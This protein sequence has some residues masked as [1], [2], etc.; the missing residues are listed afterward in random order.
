MM[1]RIPPGRNAG[2]NSDNTSNPFVKPRGLKLRFIT[3][4]VLVSVSLA[5]LLFVLHT[6]DYRQDQQRL[7]DFAAQMP[8]L[9]AQLAAAER[10][11]FL[12]WLQMLGMVCALIAGVVVLV[13][14]VFARRLLHPIS[15]LIAAAREIGA[16]VYNHP[17]E[18][19]TNDDEI[20]DLRQALEHMRQQ[21]QQTTITTDYLNTVLNSMRDAVLVTD[22]YGAIVKIN[23]AAVQLFNSNESELIGKSFADFLSES[24]RASFSIEPGSDETR[25]TV[26]RVFDG[27]TIPVSVS[28]SALSAPNSNFQGA[29][30]VARDITERKR[31]ERRIRYLARY[32]ALTKIPN[33]MQFQHMLQ[34]TIARARKAERGAALLYLDLDRFKEINDTFGH[35][36]G[37]RA[38]ETLS[39]RLTRVLPKEAVLGRLAGD[40]FAVFIEGVGDVD[41]ERGQAAI[42]ARMVLAEIGK[43]FYVQQHEVFVTAS[44]GIAF[45]PR[46]A[47]NVIDLIRNA[48]AAMYHS[49]Q[50]GGNTFAFYS[51]QMNAAAVERLMLKSKLRRALE[52]NELVILYQPKI[53]LRSGRIVG[54]EA[55]LRWRLPGHGDISPSQFIPLAEE[56]NL[57]LGIGDWVMNRVCADYRLWLKQIP[58]PGRVSI[59]LSLKQLRQSNF[60]TRCK[61]TF[62][63]HDVS[64]TCFELEITETTLMVDAKRTLK[65]LDELYGMGLHLSI[66]DFG[67][68]YSSLSALQQFPISTL[69]IDQS[70][71]RDVPGDADDATIVRTIVDMGRTM[72]MEVIAEG[73]ESREQFDFLRKHGCHYGQGRLFGDAVAADDFLDQ[74]ISQ[75]M[76]AS[77]VSRLF[78]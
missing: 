18:A 46:D 65:L 9:R 57:I 30:L 20:A 69:K 53:D 28:I 72:E 35:A 62:K 14:W 51:P 55:L 50:N 49:K 58:N 12:D 10:R 38:L 37:D 16:G 24:E 23:Q 31:A 41:D 11:E 3:Y 33:R 71:V 43:A 27:Q 73:V 77:G 29:I 34:Q 39:E 42:L 56:T 63:R 64:P 54:A 78:A 1:P 26:V 32:D 67:T 13:A 7:A 59:N 8:A 70:F 60:V 48:D 45:C 19:L 17:L 61:A 66:D 74:M 2:L 36:A 15:K 6:V 5:A 47:E 75:E 44:V 22:Q 25:E 68:G 4:A 40:E 76:G 52:R 21:L